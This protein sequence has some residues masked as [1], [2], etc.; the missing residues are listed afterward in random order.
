MTFLVSLDK[1]N[2]DSDGVWHSKLDEDQFRGIN[3]V[4]ENYCFD[5]CLIPASF[6]EV[7]SQVCS[8]MH[9]KARAMDG[10]VAHK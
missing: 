4:G 5:C 10:Q 2:A 8:V 1:D 6:F 9:R 7:L 3:E